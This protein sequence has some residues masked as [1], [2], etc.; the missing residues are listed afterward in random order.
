METTPHYEHLKNIDDGFFP[1]LEHKKCIKP[2]M[3][4]LFSY[5]L[6]SIFHTRKIY[7]VFNFILF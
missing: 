7:N 2:S 1:T 4:K 5:I 3:Y 6:Y